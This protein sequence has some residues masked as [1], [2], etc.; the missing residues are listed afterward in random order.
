MA[1]VLIRCSGSCQL[2]KIIMGGE[3]QAYG[4]QANKAASNTPV[5]LF[6]LKLNEEIDPDLFICPLQAAIHTSGQ[7][8]V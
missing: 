2:K 7:F 1:A 8:L 6:I 3:R 5:K 4:E